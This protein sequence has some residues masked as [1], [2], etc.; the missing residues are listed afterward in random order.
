MAMNSRKQVAST[1]TPLPVAVSYELKLTEL[2][3]VTLI[4][5]F[6]CVP[7]VYNILQVLN[8]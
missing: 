2:W 4:V 7:P 5:H 8:S 6:K 1:G 3:K